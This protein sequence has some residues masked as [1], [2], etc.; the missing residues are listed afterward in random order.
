MRGR[1][2]IPVIF[3]VTCLTATSA[4]AQIAV[5]TQPVDLRADPSTNHPPP[6]AVPPLERLRLIPPKASGDFFQVRSSHGA[7]GWIWKRHVSFYNRDEWR[8]GGQ[9]IDADSDGQTSRHE[10]IIEEPLTIVLFDERGGGVMAGCWQDPYG[11]DT[12]TTPS[13][14][15]VGHVVPLANACSE[16]PGPCGSSRWLSPISPV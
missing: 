8:R 15:D 13:D 9:W 14:L 2:T 6:P 4:L 10:A 3:L 1:L 7:E 16:R 11:G 5:A 12:V